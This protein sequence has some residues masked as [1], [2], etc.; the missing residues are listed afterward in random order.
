VT[1]KNEKP[2]FDLS[3]EE[4]RGSSARIEMPRKMGVG[5]GCPPPHQG[6]GLGISKQWILVHFLILILQFYL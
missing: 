5:R 4:V 2:V 3:K 6:R 1:C